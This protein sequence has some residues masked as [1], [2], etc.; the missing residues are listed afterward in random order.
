MRQPYSGNRRYEQLDQKWMIAMLK[1]Y[2][3]KLVHPEDISIR[4]P[5]PN[6]S[7]SYSFHESADTGDKP[8][9]LDPFWDNR[10][11][12]RRE[13]TRQ[14]QKWILWPQS[15]MRRDKGCPKIQPNRLSCS[16]W[17]T[18]IIAGDGRKTRL[19]PAFWRMKSWHNLVNLGRHQ[20]EG[21]NFT[22]NCQP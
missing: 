13:F 14:R 1:L 9:N 5:T 10:R 3:L 19:E 15:A 16:T 4:S 21:R 18:L 2:V 8:T 11:L 20:G 17:D 22:L 6:C 7:R 12:G